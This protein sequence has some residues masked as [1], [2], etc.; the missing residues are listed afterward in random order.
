LHFPE[1]ENPSEAFKRFSTPIEKI[2]A[3]LKYIVSENPIENSEEE[4]DGNLLLES[5]GFSKLIR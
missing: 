1:F 4:K 2:E 5:K 3:I